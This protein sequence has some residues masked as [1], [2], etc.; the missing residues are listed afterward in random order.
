MSVESFFQNYISKKLNLNSGESD[1][2]QETHSYLRAELEKRGLTKDKDEEPYTFLTGSYARDTIIR[3]PD[4]IDFFLILDRDYFLENGKLLP[5]ENIIRRLVKALSEIYPDKQVAEK[6]DNSDEAEII[7]Q[8]TSVKVMVDDNFGVDIV[9]AFENNDDFLIPDRRRYCYKITNPKKHEDIINDLNSRSSKTDEKRFK[10]IIKLVKG[11][12]RDKLESMDQGL[13]SFHLEVIGLQIFE[14]FNIYSIQAGLKEYFSK[15]PEYIQANKLHDPID[16]N[17]FVD[18]YIGKYSDIQI[19]SILVKI[20]EAI[21]IS[22]NA[23]NFT[24]VGD[25][26]SAILEWA[27]LFTDSNLEKIIFTDTGRIKYNFKI[28]AKT[29]VNPNGAFKSKYKPLKNKLS[30][31]LSI[32]FSIETNIPTP[33]ILKWRVVNKGTEALEANDLRGKIEND[34]GNYQKL[35]HTKYKGVHY[36]EAFALSNTTLLAYDKI[37]VTIR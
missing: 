21:V 11:W 8:N 35:E 34:G 4:D 9:P 28:R 3:P 13:K 23:A 7:I 14:N 19:D 15:L 20:E 31:G 29:D 24:D 32:L 36:V 22:E 30:K 1:M 17:N 27:K 6:T 33:F 10:K 2:I 26:R 5:P 12:N 16:E 25:E 37:F 18:D